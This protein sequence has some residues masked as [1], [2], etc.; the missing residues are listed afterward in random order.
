MGGQVGMI[1]LSDLMGKAMG[2]QPRKKRK[3]TVARGARRS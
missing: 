1:N 2:Q 3:M